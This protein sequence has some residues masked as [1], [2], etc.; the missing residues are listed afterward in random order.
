MRRVIPLELLGV[1]Q[2]NFNLYDENE[3]LLFAR[4]SKLT[5][6][7]LMMLNSKKVYRKEDEVFI[8]EKP[9]PV[10]ESKNIIS[11]TTTQLLITSAKLIIGDIA[12]GKSPDFTACKKARDVIL[13]E[14]KKRIDTYES[15]DEFRVI[16][17]YSFSHGLNVSMISTIIGQSLELNSVQMKELSIGALLH[18]IGKTKIPKEIIFKKKIL[19]PYEYETVKQHALYGYEIIT[20]KIKLSDN[21]A[22]AAMEHHERY[23]GGG[24]PYKLQ[25]QSITLYGQIVAIADV[26]DALVSN[27]VYKAAVPPTEAIR[28]M[29]NENKLFFNPELLARFVKLSKIENIDSKRI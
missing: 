13:E 19:T 4:G 6:S 15:I 7:N 28:I 16:D 26:Y 12:A 3:V 9:V 27:K 18:D 29:Q 1:E 5:P 10:K 11:E 23:F 22:R 14:V 17:E 2:L 24:Y 20:Q 8:E 21:I 25:G